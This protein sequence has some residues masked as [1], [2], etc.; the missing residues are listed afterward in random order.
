M[1]TLTLSSR[2][3][4]PPRLSGAVDYLGKV[5]VFLRRLWRRNRPQGRRGGR[6]FRLVILEKFRKLI[7]W[8]PSRAAVSR[9]LMSSANLGLAD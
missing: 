2:G 4:L 6:R 5:L 8:P 1:R 3:L 9:D 7:G